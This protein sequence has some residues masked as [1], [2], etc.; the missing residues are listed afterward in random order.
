MRR[1]TV[2][3]L[4]SGLLLLPLVAFADDLDDAGAT[5]AIVKQI[6]DH[7]A[8]G[9]A[10]D[11]SDEAREAGEELFPEGETGSGETRR[12]AMEEDPVFMTARVDGAPVVFKDV[13][14]DAW[15]APYVREVVNGN[16]VSGY[17]D[18]TG[19]P[20]GLYGPADS[21]TIEQLAKI[22][23]LVGKVDTSACGGTTKNET[24][25]NRWSESFIRCAEQ[26]GWAVFSDGSVPV[27]RLATRAE[28]VVTLLQALGATL[29]QRTGKVFKDVDGSTEFASSIETAANAG[30]V[31]G[32]T[33]AEGNST[34][35]FKPADPINRAEVA[36]IV[37][38]GMQVYGNMP[39][40]SAS[41]SLK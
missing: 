38:R 29:D 28:V 11:A 2:V 39:A 12:A 7:D 36:K 37:T 31:S 5:A 9:Q 27:E 23:V 25:K 4:C 17:R 8:A 34:G 1:R 22:A 19:L 33:D 26:K 35:L 40:S 21:M 30:V 15:F 32:Y 10:A 14:K 16:I 13:P 18:A 24:A 41:S 3:L 6:L 20:K